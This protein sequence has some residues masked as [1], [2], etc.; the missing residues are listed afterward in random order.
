MLFIGC[1]AVSETP[2][3]C[4]WKR[5]SQVRAFFAPKAVFHQPIPD[6]PRRAVLGDLFEEVVVR[7]EEEAQARPELVD[8]QPAPPRP[9]HVL[10]AV[11]NRERQLLQR[12]RAG[13][14]NVIAADR[15]RVEAR[16]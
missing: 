4:V 16:A 11:I 10:D 6:L 3:V 5:I 8:V 12:S 1:C 2:A 9:L 7:V 15:N 13:L 14:A